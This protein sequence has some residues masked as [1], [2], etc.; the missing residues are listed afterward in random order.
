MMVNKMFKKKNTSKGKLQKKDLNYRRAFEIS[1]I[2]QQEMQLVQKQYRQVLEEINEEIKTGM[3]RYYEAQ[4]QL[5]ELKLREALPIESV[6]RSIEEICRQY[7][8][9]LE[10]YERINKL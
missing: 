1:C 2:S 8:E 7:Q 3:E 4:R 6:N 9:I 10:M 5:I